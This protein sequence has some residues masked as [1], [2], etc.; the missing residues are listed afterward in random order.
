MSSV[1]L[2]QLGEQ[3]YFDVSLN[4]FYLT[5]KFFSDAFKISIQNFT[6]HCAFLH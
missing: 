2:E 6:Y 3:A 1:L 4:D 5:T